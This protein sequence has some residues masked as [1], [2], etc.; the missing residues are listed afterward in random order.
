MKTRFVS[1]LVLL[2]I[3]INLNPA[4]GADIS[5]MERLG[6]KV[7][8]AAFQRL[9]VSSDASDLACLTN[10]G[11]VAY[12]GKST[13]ILYD[14]ISENTKISLGKG[15]LLPVHT[16]WKDDLWFAFVQKKSEK[17]LPL[18]YVSLNE[19]GIHATEPINI[20][21]EKRQSFEPFK[22]IFGKKAFA[23]VTLANGWADG[24]PDDLMF[25]S[26]FHDH[27]CCGV[28]TGYFT[29]R[30]IQ[31]HIPLKNGENILISARPGG[32][33]MTILSIIST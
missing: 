15:N 12:K 4:A 28:A 24:I 18:T 3:F 16:R 25:G 30:F 5:D 6:R 17:E 11:Y 19:Q 22:K 32:V 2:F 9:R 23:L 31:N 20:Y 14:V 21:V 27:F 1:V 7:V 10:A 8:S 29:A 13:R 26:L 33:R